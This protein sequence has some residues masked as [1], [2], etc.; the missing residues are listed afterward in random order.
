MNEWRPEGWKR[1][2]M[3]SRHPDIFEAGASTMLKV[4]KEKGAWMTPEQMKILAPDRKYP[5]G[6]MVF[7]PEDKAE[8]SQEELERSIGKLAILGIKRLFKAL[9]L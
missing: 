4:L 8:V 9:R 3:L 1:G 2:D 7:I 6:Y 5:Y